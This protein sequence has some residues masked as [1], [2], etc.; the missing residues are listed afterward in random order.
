MV[1]DDVDFEVEILVEF[2]LVFEVYIEF[3]LEYAIVYFV[4]YWN[5]EAI[6]LFDEAV[7]DLAE[8][9]ITLCVHIATGG[10]IEPAVHSI[11]MVKGHYLGEDLFYRFLGYLFFEVAAHLDEVMVD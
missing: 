5:D 10:V 11:V 4:E 2:F 9:F 8:I 6:F 1:G 7:M 3:L